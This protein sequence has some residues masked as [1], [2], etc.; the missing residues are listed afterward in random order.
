MRLSHHSI[1]KVDLYLSDPAL[2]GFRTNVWFGLLSLN[3]SSSQLVVDG[4]EWLWALLAVMNSSYRTFF[5]LF[6]FRFG[7]FFIFLFF[8]KFYFIFKLYIT[9]VGRQNLGLHAVY[10]LFSE[11]NSLTLWLQDFLCFFLFLPAS[12]VFFVFLLAFL[13]SLFIFD[14]LLKNYFLVSFLR[15]HL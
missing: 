2:H 5:F 1:E 13:K 15:S 7:S 6:S 14:W 3:Q 12:V 9:V 4:C 8:F 11:C 10:A